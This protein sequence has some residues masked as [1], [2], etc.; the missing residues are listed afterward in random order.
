MCVN[1][2]IKSLGFPRL[3]LYVY[4]MMNQEFE[5]TV[6]CT[7]KEYAKLL[8]IKKQYFKIKD[9][10]KEALRNRSY[11]TVVEKEKEKYDMYNLSA[12]IIRE[13]NTGLVVAL[14]LKL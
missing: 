7:Y 11:H 5:P 8:E 14:D 2:F 3:F 13:N 1:V 10:G 6:T 9:L 12:K 4:L